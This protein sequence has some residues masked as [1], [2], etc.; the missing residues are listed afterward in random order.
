LPARPPSWWQAAPPSRLDARAAQATGSEAA[1]SA[2]S[3]TA[4]P[5]DKSASPGKPDQQGG[6]VPDSANI[7]LARTLY[8]AKGDPAVAEQVMAPD[9]IWDVTPGFPAGG[10]YHGFNSMT[11]DFFGRLMPMFESFYAQGEEFYADNDNH[12]FVLGH[13]H[14][15]TTHGQSVNARFIHLW[16]I[17][18]GKLAR[19]QQAADSGVVVQA[20]SR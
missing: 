10:V 19:M 8:D 17:R 13:Y 11:S 4:A 18:D 12:V 5:P 3:A 20:L 15:T 16:T 14:G 1:E 9:I 7:A 6:T 2:A